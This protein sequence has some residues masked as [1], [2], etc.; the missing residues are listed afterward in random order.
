M[1][2]NNMANIAWKIKLSFDN[3]FDTLPHYGIV[4]LA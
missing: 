4:L 1:A 2:I 3:V